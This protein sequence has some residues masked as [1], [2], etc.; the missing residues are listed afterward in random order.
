MNKSKHTA[1]LKRSL[2]Y[3]L[4]SVLRFL[5]DEWMLRTQYRI[6][7]G[8]TLHLDNPQRFTE[9]L[10]HYKAFYRNPVMKQCVDKYTVREFVAQTLGTDKYLNTLYQFCERA[11]E[12]DF[13]ALPNQFVIKTTDGGSGDNVFVCRDKK[14]L[15]I[16]SVIKTVN[17]WRNKKYTVISRE[18]AYGA[19]E[20]SRIIVEKYLEDANNKDGSIDDYKF[21]CYD[22]KFHYLWIDKNRYS[23]HR[24]GFWDKDLHFLNGVRSDCPTFETDPKQLPANIDEMVALAEQLAQGFPFVRVDLYNIKGQIIFGELTFYPWSGYVTY[25]PDNFDFELGKPFNV[26][27]YFTP[28]LT[29]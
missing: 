5:P 11:E 12:I 7:T 16:P 6:R 3:F 29:P 28:R 1:K 24:R 10:Q 2:L 27:G 8:R 14:T 9:K 15:D 21:L 17:Q 4:A 20:G 19:S 13:D 18:W 25:T 22:G 26:N 23:N